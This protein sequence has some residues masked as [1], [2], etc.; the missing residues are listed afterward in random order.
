[1][2]R[3]H[4]ALTGHMDDEGEEASWIVMPFRKG[5]VFDAGR[6]TVA[7]LWLKVTCRLDKWNWEDDEF[8]EFYVN[9]PDRRK[10]ANATQRAVLRLTL[11][12]SDCL[13]SLMI[14]LRIGAVRGSRNRFSPSPYTRLPPLSTS[15]I[16][17]SL[18]IDV[19]R[20]CSTCVDRRALIYP[21]AVVGFALSMMFA[22]QCVIVLID[23]GKAV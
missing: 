14:C 8:Q 1:M 4:S 20:P 6:I 23:T 15:S 12:K 11:S 2:K 22:S 5:S 21:F 13:I 9:S 19:S 7:E 17:G 16:R 3:C 18:N 10:A